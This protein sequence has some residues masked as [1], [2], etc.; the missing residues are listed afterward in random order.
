MNCR[1][2]RCL[3]KRDLKVKIKVTYDTTTRAVVSYSCVTISKISSISLQENQVFIDGSSVPMRFYRE[4]GN[5]SLTPENKLM[6][7]G[8]FYSDKKK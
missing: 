4:A 5:Y 1:Y 2:M 7:Q 6:W 3:T 8:K